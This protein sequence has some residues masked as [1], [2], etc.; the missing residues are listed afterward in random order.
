M[1]GLRRLQVNSVSTELN[2]RAPNWCQI[3]LGVWET[4][5][6]SGTGCKI[7]V[8]IRTFLRALPEPEL[9]DSCI[10]SEGGTQHI[11]NTA[12]V[13]SLLYPKSKR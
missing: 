11:Q 2:C 5:P 7:L 6:H 12:A 10:P 3:S 13:L 1:W 9:K 8:S 4:S